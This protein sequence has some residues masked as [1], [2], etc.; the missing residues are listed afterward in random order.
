[1]TKCVKAN[2]AVL[3]TLAGVEEQT[4]ISTITPDNNK[5]F[6]VLY[7]NGT[8]QITPVDNQLSGIIEIYDFKGR[9]VYKSSITNENWNGTKINGNTFAGGIYHVR[10]T[11]EEM[12]ITDKFVISR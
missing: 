7:T 9:L 2:L 5:S 11:A 10:L 1:M 6:N 4:G 3:A 12:A 8:I